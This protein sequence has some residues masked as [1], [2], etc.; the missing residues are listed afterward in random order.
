[1]W[2][3]RTH[4]G[5]PELQIWD[6]RMVTLKGGKVDVTQPA[7]GDVVVV[8]IVTAEQDAALAMF[9]A[10]TQWKAKVYDYV[11]VDADGKAVVIAQTQGFLSAGD[12]AGA[13]AAAHAWLV[14]ECAKVER[15]AVEQ[16]AWDEIET[17]LIASRA[18]ITA[19]EAVA[20]G[21]DE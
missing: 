13:Q 18:R 7:D 20:A 8:R 5:Y 15:T 2:T 1:M 6:V 11:E 19:D 16:S 12:H 9:P 21:K 3:R 17:A 14:E 10:R 4:K